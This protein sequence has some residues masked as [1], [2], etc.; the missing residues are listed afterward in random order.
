MRF[1]RQAE[2]RDQA[3]WLLLQPVGERLLQGQPV[4]PVEVRALAQRPATRNLLWKLLVETGHAD[5]F[6]PEL[7]TRQ[8]EAESALAAWLMLPNELQAE[9]SAIEL[10]EIVARQFRET[11]V[12][13]Y[14]LKFKMPPGHW[15][16]EEWQMGVVGPFLAED[17]PFQGRFGAFSRGQDRPGVTEP[18][19]LVDW[20]LALL[21]QKIPT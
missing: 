18:G 19:A 4:D 1:A 5:W 16:G 20:Y 6:P 11:P 2:K 12:E 15:S 7:L 13:L 14:V 17:A 9:P 21:D 10:M 8:S 3:L